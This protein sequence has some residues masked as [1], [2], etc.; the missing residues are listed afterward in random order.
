MNGSLRM[1]LVLGLIAA[2][3]AGALAAVNA[4]TAPIIEENTDLRLQ[5]TLSSVLEAEEFELQEGT[6]LTLW[7]AYSEGEL[8]GYVVRLLAAGYDPSGIDLLVGIDLE[9]TVS[10]VYIFGH[11]ETPGLGDKIG[12][13]S[14]LQQFEDLG[15]GDDIARGEDVDGIS[16]ATSSSN[17]VIFGVRQAVQFVGVYAG[18]VEEGV[19]NLADIPDGTYTGSASGH[20]DTIVVEV[21]IEGGQ[22]LSVEIVEEN[23][24]PSYAGPA[25]EQIP[26]RMVDEQQVDVDVVSGSTGTSTGIINAVSDALA[27]FASGDI[28]IASLANGSYVG[29]AA[30]FGGEVTV[31]VMVEDGEIIDIQVLEHNDTPSYAEP[32]HEQLTE[33]V[34]DA[35]SLDVNLVSGATGSSNGFIDAIK[36]ALRSQPKVDISRLPDGDYFAEADSFGGLLQVRVVVADGA[37]ETIQVLDHYD[38]PG[39]AE[40]AFT[41]LI[42][43][44]IDAQALDVDLYS[45]ATFSSQGLIDAVE[46]ALRSQPR[47]DLSAIPDGTYRGSGDS[48]GG[49]LELEVTL[50][51]GAI[52]AV[53]VLE[54][55]DTPD[56]AAPAFETLE[57][58][59]VEAQN[60]YVDAVSG[61]TFSSQGWLAALEDALRQAQSD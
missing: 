33:R 10:G 20:L 52:E 57:Q 39:I 30:G 38:T 50:A 8:V 56:V 23:D 15:L 19:I 29:T 1:I 49:T 32:A 26:Q 24:T 35:Q 59:V 25:V 48:F 61:A 28:D 3:A 53:A 40:P 11:S 42:D 47:L 45:G 54:H 44:V 17:G 41:E 21:T 2:L 16:G 37:I 43:W 58:R 22:L 34:V 55:S 9:G 5:N 46:A 12:Q 27:E 18:L 60:I 6:E 14:F 13:T 4:W 51:G 7:H 36:S 31:E